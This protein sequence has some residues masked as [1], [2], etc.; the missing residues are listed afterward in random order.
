METKMCVV[1]TISNILVRSGVQRSSNWRWMRVKMQSF[2]SS[3]STNNKT[4]NRWL[5][6]KQISPQGKV[7]CWLENTKCHL[8]KPTYPIF[9][10]DLSNKIKAYNR[11]FPWCFHSNLIPG[12]DFTVQ[13]SP[14]YMSHYIY[15]LGAIHFNNAKV[16]GK[17]LMW[18]HFI[19]RWYPYFHKQLFHKC[20]ISLL[21]SGLDKLR[22]CGEIELD[23]KVTCSVKSME[24]EN[25]N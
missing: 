8:L 17:E 5:R 3:L 10:V 11:T 19:S 9:V 24:T 2:H 4:N 14:N 20:S 6:I 12:I 23:N 13:L 22:S 21:S 18:N 7:F 16:Q 25:F 15:H 1:L